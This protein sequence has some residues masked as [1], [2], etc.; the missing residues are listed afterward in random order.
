[1]ISI[2][3]DIHRKYVGFSEVYQKV[4]NEKTYLNILIEKKKEIIQLEGIITKLTI[5]SNKLKEKFKKLKN[6]FIEISKRI[7]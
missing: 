5:E 7:K 2:N 6:E 4:E 3:D 1:M